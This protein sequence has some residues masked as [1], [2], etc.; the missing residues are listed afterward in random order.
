MDQGKGKRFVFLG[1]IPV[2]DYMIRVHLEE[3]AAALGGQVLVVGDRLLLPLGTVFR[4]QV[5]GCAEPLYV[6]PAAIGELQQLHEATYCALAFGGKHPQLEDMSLCAAPE[7]IAAEMAARHPD[8]FRSA[9]VRRIVE[10]AEPVTI[11]LGGNNKNIIE[12]IK[13]LY[14][15][16]ELSGCVEEIAF[17]HH[18]FCDTRA[19]NFPMV[20]ELYE[21]LGVALGAPED[22]HLDG[23]IPRTGYVLT[24]VGDEGKALDRIILAN[25]GNEEII[26]LERLGK[27]YRQL[28]YTLRKDDRFVET[29]LVINSL[30]NQEE[31]RLVVRLLRT[32]FASGVTTYLCP[33]LTFL[34][35]VDRLVKDQYYAADRE[36]FFEFQNDFLEKAVL[37]F[38][39]CLILNKDELSALSPMA[40]KRGIDA[41]ASI[42]AR[43]MNH[44]RGPETAEGGK[45]VVT[46]GSKGARYTERL[47][48][49]QATAFWHKA[50]LSDDHRVR[51]AERRIVCGDDFVTG[52]V[53]TLGAGDVFT[54]IFIGLTALNWDGG[55]ALR[56]ATLGAQH[57]IQTRV[58]PRIADMV[59]VD[60]SHIRLGTETELVDV[61]SHHV[62]ESG[63]PTR[64]GTIAH[65]V[66]T[67]HTAQIQHPFRE[68]LE[69]AKRIA[70]R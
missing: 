30:T 4:L 8:T 64:Y 33:T 68:T 35:G 39:N 18:F 13:T 42:L 56:A 65:T 25:R 38:V 59:A 19:P 27:M 34:K 11:S 50:H 51:F 41:A 15:S 31:I 32:A 43:T 3:L 37:P 40:A 52:L 54:G 29:H 55:H 44:G 23:L 36:R 28:E 1:G 47:R 61:I 17:E 10:V 7:V 12:E 5:A 67:I 2:F 20:R 60:E 48:P 9:T 6:N 57:F 16:P 69:V 49:D 53:S 26:P 46:G 66:I 14:A 63:D 70:A 62:A 22:L 21:R 58:K 45:V 24:V